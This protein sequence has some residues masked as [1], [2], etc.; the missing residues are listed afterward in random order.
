MPCPS[1]VNIPI[2]FSYFNNMHLFGDRG[3]RFSYMGFT[4]G[5]DGGSPS[6]AS[7]CRDCG[8][9]EKACPQGLPIREHLREVAKEMQPFYFE[10][11]VGL[12][13]GY[14]RIRRLLRRGKGS[15][16]L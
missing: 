1:G 5:M 9:C 3:L 8:K 15:R 16:G 10:P 12:I 11:A 4:G 2:C 14:Y 7:L 6:Y 13:R